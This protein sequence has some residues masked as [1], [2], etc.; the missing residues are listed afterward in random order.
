MN[1]TYDALPTSYQVSDVSFTLLGATLK[2]ETGEEFNLSQEKRN[3][4][5]IKRNLPT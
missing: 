5:R 3:L 2:R 4:L 1:Q